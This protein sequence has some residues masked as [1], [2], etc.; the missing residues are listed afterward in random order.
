MTDFSDSKNLP[1][2]NGRCKKKCSFFSNF[3]SH[4]APTTN[5]GMQKW[6]LSRNMY[7]LHTHVFCT[8]V[9]D[10]RAQSVLS[11]KIFRTGAQSEVYQEC[12]VG[13]VAVQ[14]VVGTGRLPPSGLYYQSSKQGGCRTVHPTVSL[15]KTVP[16]GTT[17]RTVVHTSWGGRKGKKKRERDSLDAFHICKAGLL[18]LSLSL[19]PLFDDGGDL[20]K[21][22]LLLSSWKVKKKARFQ[23]GKKECFN[24]PTNIHS[25]CPTANGAMQTCVSSR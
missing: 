4:P 14:F 7:T 6:K 21:R 8:F 19:S 1:K 12:V 13:R 25:A 3:F 18:S 10:L 9:A 16:S 11:S 5:T 17:V 2:K 24:I 20:I 22:K 23:R 15:R